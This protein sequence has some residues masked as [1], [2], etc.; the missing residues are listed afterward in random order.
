MKERTVKQILREAKRFRQKALTAPAAH[1]LYVFVPWADIPKDVKS[2]FLFPEEV[3][4][5]WDK[6][7]STD[8]L[9]V[10][11]ELQIISILNQLSKRNIVQALMFTSMIL[12]DLFMLGKNKDDY[13]FHYF[14]AAENYK[15][16]LGGPTLTAD[17]Y[18]ISTIGEL[19]LDIAKDLE[20]EL[21]FNIEEIIEEILLSIVNKIAEQGASIGIHAGIDAAFDKYKE[22]TGEDLLADEEG[23]EEDESKE[24]KPEVH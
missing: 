20:L 11:I 16:D 21:E 2:F 12:A 14:I 10:D 1:R 4:E 23:D 13:E 9:K 8:G 15:E 22:I 3:I 5:N 24:E 18:A 6:E 17:I 7:L 19:L